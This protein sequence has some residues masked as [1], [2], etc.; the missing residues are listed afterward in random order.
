MKKPSVKAKYKYSEFKPPV[1]LSGAVEKIWVFESSDSLLDKLS[2][3]IIPDYTASFILI[4]PLKTNQLRL[5]ITGPNTCNFPFENF[6]NQITFGF[7]F[8]PHYVS[9]L[10]GVK[11]KD[12]LNNKINLY[13]H[14]SPDAIELL[15]LKL[16]EAVTLRKKISAISDFIAPYLN[17]IGIVHDEITLIIDKIVSSG[18]TLKL[19]EIYSTLAIS[20]RQFQR[21]FIKRTGLSPKEFSR[22]VRFHKV[23]RKLVRNNFRHFDT[24]VESGYYDQSHYY[25]EFKEFL[26]MLP[27]RFESRQ[28]KISHEKLLE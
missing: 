11:P 5:Y 7:R 9:L 24:L 17:K 27:T 3:N 28:K 10:K 26:G 23:T 20:Q 22:I 2:Y 18:G 15:K 6:S 21:N 19:E 25:R 1:K 13:K 14:I 8:F 16:Y 12:T 4:F